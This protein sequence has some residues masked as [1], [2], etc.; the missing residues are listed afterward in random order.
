[1][2]EMKAISQGDMGTQPP[3]LDLNLE[4]MKN[5]LFQHFVPLVQKHIVCHNINFHI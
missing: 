2:W 3:L 4:Y 5:Q 1:M